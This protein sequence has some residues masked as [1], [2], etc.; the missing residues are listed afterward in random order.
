MQSHDLSQTI[1]IV[2]LDEIVRY[3]QTCDIMKVHMSKCL[4]VMI[5]KNENIVRVATYNVFSIMM[6]NADLIIISWNII[7]RKN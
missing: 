3:P 5:F 2:A 6:V 4:F 7:K 1:I